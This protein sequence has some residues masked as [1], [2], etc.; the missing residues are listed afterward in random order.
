MKMMWDDERRLA[1]CV[2]NMRAKVMIGRQRGN[3]LNLR[4]TSFTGVKTI[5]LFW[6]KEKSLYS[7]AVD[8]S[9]EE[10][11]SKLV[12]VRKGIVTFLAN[13][14]FSGEKIV[15]LERGFNR[16]RIAGDHASLKTSVAL[17]KRSSIL[18]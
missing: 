6:I 13:E 10:G 2:N 14:T 18:E 7:I 11:R 1:G 8:L 15:V 3:Q 5:G 16:I 9:V 12:L 17:S 4:A